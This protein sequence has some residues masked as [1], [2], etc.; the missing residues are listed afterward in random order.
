M[1]HKKI[2]IVGGGISGLSAGVYAQKAGFDSVILEKH[3]ALG[4]LCAFWDRYGYHIDGC[5]HWLTGTTPNTDLYQMWL[6]LGA[7]ESKKDIYYQD[8]AGVINYDNKTLTLYCDINKLEQEFLRVAPEDKKQIHKLINALIK[9]INLPLPLYEPLNTM[10]FFSFLKTGFMLIP[11]LGFM[12]KMGLS[13]CEKYSKKFKSPI[14]RY[15]LNNWQSGPGSLY[16]MLYCFGTII[17]HNGGLTKRGSKGLVVNIADNYQRLGGKIRLSS[18]VKEIIIKK[19]K[20]VGV[21]LESGEEIYGDYVVNATDV[22]HLIRKLLKNKYYEH[23][24]EKRFADY[25]KYPCPTSYVAY[26]AIDK[27]KI[28]DSMGGYSSYF[29]I[30]KPFMLAN[31][32]VEH[33]NVRSYAYD[34]YFIN[35]NKTVIQ[36]YIEQYTDSYIFWDFLYEDKQKYNEYKKSINDLI[37][38]NVLKQY[39]N[40]S[41]DDF[42]L[43]DSFTPKTLQRYTNT[44]MGGFM[45]FMMTTNSKLLFHRGKIRG[46]KNLYIASQWTQTPGGLPLAAASG[47]F[48][49]Q[50]ILKKEKLNHLFW[51]R[52]LYKYSR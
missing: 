20:A 11:Y 37:L 49:I 51:L 14:M 35:K 41:R 38:D 16:A 44:Y 2:I 39:P 50:R 29:N 8:N 5:I 13:S 27:D 43:L 10:N 9:I 19:K 15:F 31:K 36:V 34:D 21:K 52:H 12:L 24:Y 32:R 47:K 22:H 28:Y 23:N 25:K 30:D 26:F 3:S 1:N 48:A 40:L 17:F 46:I 18:P 42:K 45:S 6:D 7:F 4:G 33:L